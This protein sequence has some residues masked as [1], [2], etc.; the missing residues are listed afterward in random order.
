M[1]FVRSY[2]TSILAILL[3]ISLSAQQYELNKGWKAIRATDIKKTGAEISRAGFPLTNWIPATVPGTVLTTQLNNKLIPDP[4]YGMNNNKIPDLFNVGKD[5]YTYWFVNGL[6]EKAPADGE[7]V[8]AIFRG[9]NNSCDIFLNGQKV[10]DHTT[11]S[12]Y[13]RQRYDLT[14]FLAK[15]GRNRLAVI[16]YPPDP[17]GNPNGGQGG[18]GTIAHNI[19]AQYTAGWDWIQPVRDRNTGI[20]DRVFIERTKQV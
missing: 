9:V 15:D 6:T 17:A 19:T 11:K 5:Y 10:N 20:W 16:V 1:S 13:L 3:S 2:I 14:P 8:W 18:D 7:K 4:F 12:M